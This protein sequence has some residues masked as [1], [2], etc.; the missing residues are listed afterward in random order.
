MLMYPHLNT[1]PKRTRTVFRDQIFDDAE[2]S[3]LSGNDVIS[4][5]LTNNDISL[6]FGKTVDFLF[7]TVITDSS[8]Y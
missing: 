7:R 5:I 1:S 6:P 8:P 3:F 2:K 4:H